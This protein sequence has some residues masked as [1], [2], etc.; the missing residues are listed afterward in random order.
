MN[1][2]ELQDSELL[3][4]A[5]IATQGNDRHGVTIQLLWQVARSDQQL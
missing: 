2:V 3:S 1:L 4:I 5:Y